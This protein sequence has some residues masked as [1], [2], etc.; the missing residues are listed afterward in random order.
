[1]FSPSPLLE[2]WP[3]MP[4]NKMKTYDKSMGDVALGEPHAH[5][6]ARRMLFGVRVILALAVLIAGLLLVFNRNIAY[7]AI[8]PIPV[9]YVV[10][11][12]LG[13]T[14]R[15]SRTSVLRSADQSRIS[16]E[17]VEVDVATNRSALI[18]EISGILVMGVF[19]VAAS[20]YELHMVLL[21]GFVFLVYCCFLG[22]PYWHLFLSQADADERHKVAPE[23]HNQV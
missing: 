8:L 11:M 15:R 3:Y 16:D 17:E 2:E 5:E 22:L 10:L 7:L 1:M 19:L 20:L 6:I 23:R 14:E 4:F 13:Y 9:L 21:T 18:L 12:S